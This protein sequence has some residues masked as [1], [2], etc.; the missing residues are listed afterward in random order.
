MSRTLIILPCLLMLIL[1]SLATGCGNSA[2]EQ[3]LRA[4]KAGHDQDALAAYSAAIASTFMVSQ[5]RSLAYAS[6]AGILITQGKLDQAMADLDQALE[7]DRQSEPGY[8]NRTVLYLLKGETTKAQLDAKR[9]LELVP[10][11]QA[12]RRLFD[13]AEKPPP[14]FTLPLTWQKAN[15]GS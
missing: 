3:G 8:Y 12:A 6:R 4:E 7:Q 9:L 10:Q 5:K 13:L 15:S 11:N 14:R 2:L 1:A